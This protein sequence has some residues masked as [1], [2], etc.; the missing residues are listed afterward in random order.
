[1]KTKYTQLKKGKCPYCEATNRKPVLAFGNKML[2]VSGKNTLITVDL[3]TENTGQGWSTH[4]EY[5]P[6]CGRKLS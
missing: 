4:I 6:M 2:L 1:M 3:M 5:C